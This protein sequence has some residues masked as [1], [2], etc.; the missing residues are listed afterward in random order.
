[1]QWAIDGS[2]TFDLEVVPLSQIEHAWQRTDLRGKRLA[3]NPL[4]P[5]VA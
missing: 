3:V 2:L 4:P 5:V 1:M